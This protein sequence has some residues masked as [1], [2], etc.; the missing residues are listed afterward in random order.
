MPRS[1]R[2]CDEVERSP[3]W[4]WRRT[5]RPAP[6]RRAPRLISPKSRRYLGTDLGAISIAQDELTCATAPRASPGVATLELALYDGSPGAFSP[7]GVS[8]EYYRLSAPSFFPTS[9]PL[10]GGS[11]V[12]VQPRHNLVTI[13]AQSR[14]DLDGGSRVRVALS[15]C[16]LQAASNFCNLSLS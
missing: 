3:R 1:C 14:H 13:S 16:K 9:G 7:T 8:F 12:R 15:G 10:D 2:D 6:P 4:G 11:R 5:S